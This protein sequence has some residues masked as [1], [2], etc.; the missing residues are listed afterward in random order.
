MELS[1]KIEALLF[2]RGE[3]VGKRELAKMLGSKDAEIEQGITELKSKLENRGIALLEKDDEVELRTAPEAS[4]LIEKIRKE[5][6]S[7]DL[8]KAGAE[9]LAIILYRNPVTRAD[10]DYIRGVNSTFILRNLLIRGLVE[11]VQ[12]PNDQRSFHYKPTFELLAH[13]GIKNISELPEYT[14]VQEELEKFTVSQK[15]EEEDSEKEH[16]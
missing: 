12:N 2:F 8:G 16:A 14:S 4:E 6:L 3:P 7:R 10:I 1:A 15:A 13:L 5:E 9:T 11:R